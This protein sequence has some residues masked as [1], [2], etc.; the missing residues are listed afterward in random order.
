MFSKVRQLFDEYYCK[1]LRSHSKTFDEHLA[2]EVRV[3]LRQLQYIVDRAF[4]LEKRLVGKK[5]VQLPSNA[6]GE[7]VIKHIFSDVAR[8]DCSKSDY[9]LAAFNEP[10][11]LRLLLEVFYYTAHRIRVILRDAG[12]RL[13]DIKGFEAS[14]VRDV[15]NHLVMHPTKKKGV[16]V[17]TFAFGGPV[18]PQLKPIR[19]TG[20]PPGTIDK[21]LREN[22][23]EFR[24]AVERILKKALQK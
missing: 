4:S 3:R 13:P 11:E 1:Q 8:P 22:A 5:K 20:D 2:Q 23:I 6:G 10:D 9:P 19:K 21:G 24:D 12:D 15:R 7:V 14:G 17:M 16:R 18:G